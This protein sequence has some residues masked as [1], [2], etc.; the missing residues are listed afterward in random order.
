MNQARIRLAMMR[1]Q[2]NQ[3]ICLCMIVRDEAPAIARC[4]RSVRQHLPLSAW[5]IVDTG[6]VDDTPAIIRQELADLPGELVVSPWTDDYAFHRNESLALGE[7]TGCSWLFTID[8]D[9][10]LKTTGTQQQLFP[11]EG[12]AYPFVISNDGHSFTRPLLLRAGFWRFKGVR[13]EKPF[14]QGKDLEKLI[15]VNSVVSSLF[16]DASAKDG[17]RTRKGGKHEC[18]LAALRR[19]LENNPDDMDTL[20]NIGRTLIWLGNKDEGC[21]VLGKYLEKTPSNVHPYWHLQ[22]FIARYFLGWIGQ[23]NNRVDHLLRAWALCQSPEVAGQ[24]ALA[25]L[26]RKDWNGVQTWV[27]RLELSK[28]PKDP[29]YVVDRRWF[30]FLKWDTLFC[31]Q[32]VTRHQREAQAA[33]RMALGCP[34]LP[35]ERCL[36]LMRFL[37]DHPAA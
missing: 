32:W 19:T 14:P 17:G 35:P 4:I 3:R 20:Y 18:D 22:N 25:C 30:G 1:A 31:C 5:A 11:L 33:A 23:E 21:E 8:A 12:H 15:R 28:E 7:K 27:E 34:D 13:H 10:L 24:L 6:S 36:Y 26:S 29:C 9:E 37:V 2:T 16:V